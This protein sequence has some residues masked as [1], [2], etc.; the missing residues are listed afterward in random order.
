MSH[1][2]SEKTDEAS[3]AY[4]ALADC[5]VGGFF[6]RKGDIVLLPK[7]DKPLP[8]LEPIVEAPCAEKKSAKASKNNVTK[9]DLGMGTPTPSSRLTSSDMVTK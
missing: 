2:S 8:F 7:K 1:P 4:R 3:I 5:R 9:E 6:R